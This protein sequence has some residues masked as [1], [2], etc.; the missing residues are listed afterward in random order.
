MFGNVIRMNHLIFKFQT[1][2]GEHAPWTPPPPR[3]A[4]AF[5]PCKS[6][7][8]WNPKVGIS[9]YIHTYMERNSVVQVIRISPFCIS[10]I[11]SRNNR[12]PKTEPSSKSNVC[13]YLFVYLSLLLDLFF[14]FQEKRLM[15][16]SWFV[17]AL[18]ALVTMS[19]HLCTKRNA[20]IIKYSR[21]SHGNML[22]TKGKHFKVRLSTRCILIH[23]TSC[24][25]LY[26]CMM[27]P[28]TNIFFQYN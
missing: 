28:R 5:S 18:P 12:W 26:S 14:H 25:L 8:F 16:I 15:V 3:R 7:S 1:F 4:P 27:N 17:T 21:N 6:P 13:F 22:L 9:A 11:F 20:F 19:Y 24:W 2:P 10:F 23:H